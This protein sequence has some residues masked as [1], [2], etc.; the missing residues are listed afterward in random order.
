MLELTPLQMTML[1]NSV[2]MAI[3][4]FISIP[5]TRY[6]LSPETFYIKR[7]RRE[8]IRISHKEMLVR[9]CIGMGVVFPLCI[10][11]GALIIGWE[12]FR[13]TGWLILTTSLGLA[14][15]AGSYAYFRLLKYQKLNVDESE[16]KR[17]EVDKIF[18]KRAS[19][20]NLPK[21]MIPPPKAVRFL[22]WAIIIASILGSVDISF[23]PD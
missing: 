11:L 12:A 10:I 19:L 2:G 22:V 21:G 8:S 20:P 6:F 17:G 3:W 4:L 23:Q 5:L 13:P 15:G 9:A 1:R 7:F 16:C 14:M 18:V